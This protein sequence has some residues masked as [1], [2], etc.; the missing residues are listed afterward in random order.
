MQV[1]L[2]KGNPRISKDSRIKISSQTRLYYVILLGS[3]FERPKNIR[4]V[5][6]TLGSGNKGKIYK[7]LPNVIKRNRDHVSVYH[8]SLCDSEK[9]IL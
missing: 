9:L 1:R 8:D 3:V 4:Q 2:A 5:E 6:I 7:R